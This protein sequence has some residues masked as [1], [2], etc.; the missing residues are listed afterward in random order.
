MNQNKTSSDN[1]NK[2]PLQVLAMTAQAY[3]LSTEG[4]SQELA[5]R[6]AAFHRGEKAKTDALARVGC[7]ESFL[8]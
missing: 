5:E 3:G 7:E 4:T 8:A 2:I 6:I 1:W